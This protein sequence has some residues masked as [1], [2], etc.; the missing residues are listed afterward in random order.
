MVRTKRVEEMVKA[1]RLKTEA[2]LGVY[3]FVLK[4]TKHRDK[5][6]YIYEIRR[7]LETINITQILDI[8]RHVCFFYLHRCV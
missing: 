4:E 8:F 7:R 5:S 6:C 2:K 3:S 1:R